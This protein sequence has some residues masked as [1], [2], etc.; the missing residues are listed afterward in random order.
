MLYFLLERHIPLV[1]SGL[2][3]ILLRLEIEWPD[4]SFF[5]RSPV[6][7]EGGQVP[8]LLLQLQYMGLFAVNL[9]I[10]RS[11]LSLKPPSLIFSDL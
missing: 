6:R 1:G 5:E 10:K 8:Y 7:E 3:S 4:L 9:T 2:P 11:K